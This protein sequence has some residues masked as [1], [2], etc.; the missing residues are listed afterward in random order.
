MTPTQNNIVTIPKI[1]WPLQCTGDRH[2][3]PLSF[4]RNLIRFRQENYLVRFRKK[5]W[6]GFKELRY[7]CQKKP[8]NASLTF[9]PCGLDFTTF[10]FPTFACWSIWS[11][12][13]WGQHCQNEEGSWQTW[14]NN[15]H[16][17]HPVILWQLK[18]DF[19]WQCWLL[20]NENKTQM[21]DTTSQ[22]HQTMSFVLIVLI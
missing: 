13:W 4:A 18:I 16:L 7:I 22:R 20:N 12:F 10:F 21:T 1:T 11:F 6:F 17:G 8:Y 2:T 3:W 19:H 5:S 15:F 9:F 14:L